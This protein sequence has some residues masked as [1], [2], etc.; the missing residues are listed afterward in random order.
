MSS[1]PTLIL[2]PKPEPKPA[3]TS[4]KHARCCDDKEVIDVEEAYD[5]ICKKFRLDEEA[6]DEI[7][8]KPRL[9]EEEDPWQ[10][11][12]HFDAEDSPPT[13]IFIIP[14]AQMEPLDNNNISDGAP[15]SP[16]PSTSHQ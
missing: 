5:E 6:Y 10:S 14:A 11:W 13:G 2:P 7:C 16:K 3:S 12:H 15:D 4:R 9:D 1:N 8:K